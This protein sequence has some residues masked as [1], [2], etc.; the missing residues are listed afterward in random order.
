[1]NHLARFKVKI[2]QLANHIFGLFALRPLSIDEDNLSE[3]AG[4][5]KRKIYSEWDFE[6][7]MK[8]AWF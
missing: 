2:S 7:G 8:M 4:F 5:F 3:E 6:D 1:M